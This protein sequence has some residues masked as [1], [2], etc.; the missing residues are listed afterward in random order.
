[1]K[2]VLF[3]L[4]VGLLLSPIYAQ[5]SSL[6]DLTV[7]KIMRDQS[8]WI[9]T[10]PSNIS[11]SRDSKSIYFNWNPDK[12]PSSSTYKISING[13]QAEKSEDRL[14]G[15]PRSYNYNKDKSKIVFARGGDIYIM[16]VKTK[17]ETQ[18][19]STEVRDS[20]PSFH[21]EENIITFTSANNLFFIDTESGFTKQLTNF[22]II[23]NSPPTRKSNSTANRGNRDQDRWLRGDQLVTSQ[24]LKERRTRP[25]STGGFRAFSRET[26]TENIMAIE[27]ENVRNLELSADGKYVSYQIFKRGE[28]PA[29]GT[30]V[31]NYVTS[32]G[33]TTN[34]NAHAKVGG[35]PSYVQIGIYD[36]ENDSS[37]LVDIEQLVGISDLPDYIKDYP[38]R[39]YEKK[40][41]QV[42][43]SAVLWSKDGSYGVLEFRSL[44]HK[45]RWLVRLNPNNGTLETIERQ[46]DEAWVGW[47]PGIGR[48]FGGG[49]LGFMPDNET[50]YFQ[51]EESGYSHLYTYNLKTKAKKQ[52]TEGDFEIYSPQLSK[53]GKEWFFTANMKH[54]GIRHFYSMPAKGGKIKQITTE[55][56]NNE[57]SI[58]PDEKYIAVRYSYSNKPWE[59]FVMENKAGAQFTQLT[60]SLTDE[61]KGYDWIEPEMITFNAEDGEEVHARLYKPENANGAA[62]VF[63]HGAGYL[64]NA[65][66]WW[67]GYSREYMF[68]NMLMAQGYTVID[69]D[70]RA[71]SGYGRDWRTGIYRH[72]GGKDLSDNIDGAKYL[73]AEHGIDPKRIGMYGGSY[74]GFITLF[75]MFKHPDVISAG[76]ALRSVT[77]WAH[78]NNGYTTPILNTPL[79]DPLAYKRSSPIYFA[80]GLQGDLLIAHGM[81]DT[82]VHFQDVVRLAQ[83]LIELGKNK[84]E[85]AVYPV[86]SHGFVTPSSWTDEYKRIFKLFE[87]TIGNK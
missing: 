42:T 16:D 46:R 22:E 68:N 50:L 35:D 84:W 27:V 29:K 67:S 82:N 65:H 7:D 41:R 32:S 74:G 76:A 47:G 73:V 25:R 44:D 11:W 56:G 9:G 18:L 51:S 12:E 63:V 17:K 26:S 72:M 21:E 30:I 52:L 23:D 37:Y 33:Y 6:Q 78:Y 86:E 61:F 70:Y 34:I 38:D 80:E 69:I 31:P 59:L 8:K 10:A 53:N 2:K 24:I 28:N 3:V 20:N 45:D 1:M 79:E 40:P 58:S 77:D 5:Q 49:T 54:P 48:G 39:T 14:E 4:L 55:D 13:G 60:E 15:Y 87:N 36:I 75:G 71:S 81:V 64:Q 83:K 57:V 43:S 66:Y 19:T 62:V 85:M